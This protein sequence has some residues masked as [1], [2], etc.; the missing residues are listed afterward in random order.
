MELEKKVDFPLK[1]KCRTKNI[2][3][4]CIVSAPVHPDK[5]YLGAIEGVF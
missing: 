5:A 2:I 3:Y 4:K 1:G